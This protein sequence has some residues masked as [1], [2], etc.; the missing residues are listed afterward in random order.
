LPGSPF[1]QL[2]GLKQ[3]LAQ[4]TIAKAEA[5]KV[6]AA[7]KAA[8]DKAARLFADT[9]GE[10]QVL[11]PR[12]AA[13]LLASKPAPIA[14]QRHK[15][16]QQVMQDSLSDEFGVE[17]LLETDQD[18][19]YRAQGIGTDVLLKLRRGDWAIQGQLDLHGF[20]VEAA[21]ES[22]TAFINQAA[23]RG[24]RCV[25]VVH[26][27]GLGSKDKQPVLKGR[28]RSWLVQKQAVIAFAAARPAEG[29]AGALV[30]L[31]VAS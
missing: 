4:Q 28:V 18:L 22:L 21:R 25:R 7:K 12:N 6:A 24:W 14:T 15:D 26:G 1:A 2:Q 19:S 9:V 20:R 8:A 11:K 17:Q 30:V 10:V 29:G 16:E 3:T 31:L 27:K 5:A 13:V 23:N